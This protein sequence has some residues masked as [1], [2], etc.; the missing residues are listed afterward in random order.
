MSIEDSPAIR[1]LDRATSF[2]HERK[3]NEEVGD[4]FRAPSILLISTIPDQGERSANAEDSDDSDEP[5]DPPKVE[6][7]LRAVP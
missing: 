6:E 4:P 3:R 7:K 5:V 1:K 2:Y